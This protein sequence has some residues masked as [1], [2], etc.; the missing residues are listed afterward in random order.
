MSNDNNTLEEVTKSYLSTHDVYKLNECR[1]AILLS[2]NISKGKHFLSILD[3]IC[4]EDEDPVVKKDSVK[5]L[6]EVLSRTENVFEGLEVIEFLSK[7]TNLTICLHLCVNS[8]KALLERHFERAEDKDYKALERYFR[9]LAEK[10]I[11]QYPQQCRI[12][13]L[14]ISH[15]MVELVVK[16]KVAE[17]DIELLCDT[18]SEEKD[19]RNLLT[20]FELLSKLAKSVARKDEEFESIAKTYL[21]YFPIQFVP[22]KRDK[23]CIRPLELKKGLLECFKSNKRL[24]EYSMELL[25]DSLYSD[26]TV[27]ENQSV[28]KDTL[29]FLKNCK[30]VYRSN[31]D[32]FAKYFIQV[33]KMELLGTPVTESSLDKLKIRVEEPRSWERHSES[34]FARSEQTGDSRVNVVLGTDG[35]VTGV[36]NLMKVYGSPGNRESEGSRVTSSVQSSRELSE[37]EEN[38]ENVMG[39][40]MRGTGSMEEKA[41]EGDDLGELDVDQINKIGNAY[42]K[43]SSDLDEKVWVFGEIMRL[44]L[45]S[46][47]DVEEKEVVELLDGIRKTIHLNY[48]LA[49]MV[50]VLSENS[51]L[52]NKIIERI[53]LP[54]IKDVYSL[55]DNS[56]RNERQVGDDLN[57]DDDDLEI[58]DDLEDGDEL[59][60]GE[61]SQPVEKSSDEKSG[62]E[63]TGDKEWNKIDFNRKGEMCNIHTIIS[64]CIMPKILINF[65]NDNISEELLV[66]LLRIDRNNNGFFKYNKEG[67]SNYL[68]LLLLSSSIVKEKV[69]YEV[70]ERVIG[71]VFVKDTIVVSTSSGGGIDSSP[72]NTSRSIDSSTSNNTSADNTTS[73]RIVV[74]W[75][76]KDSYW[77]E[78]ALNLKILTAIYKSHKGICYTI[79]KVLNSM[80]PVNVRVKG[81]NYIL[82]RMGKMS[83]KS[84]LLI[85]SQM[86]ELLGITLN[87]W[88]RPKENYDMD[89]LVRN[90]IQ[91]VFSGLE[92]MVRTMNRKYIT[93]YSNMDHHKSNSIGSRYPESPRKDSS[94]DSYEASSS[95]I[96]RCSSDSSLVMSDSGPTSIPN[97]DGLISGEMSG[98]N[99]S[100]RMGS[101]SESIS[102]ILMADYKRV[103]GNGKESESKQH[104]GSNVTLIRANSDINSSNSISMEVLQ[105]QSHMDSFRE[106]VD[107]RDEKDR[108]GFIGYIF[109][110]LKEKVGTIDISD[111]EEK[112]EINY[113]NAMRIIYANM[114]IDVLES[115][116]KTLFMEMYERRRLVDF[117]ATTF[118][119]YKNALGVAEDSLYV[120]VF[121]AKKVPLILSIL[122]SSL[123][124]DMRKYIDHR[125]M[126]INIYFNRPELCE[127]KS[128]HTE[129]CLENIYYNYGSVE[130]SLVN[131]E[132]MVVYNEYL[133]NIDEVFECTYSNGS[134]LVKCV[135]NMYKYDFKE[136]TEQI[137]LLDNYKLTMREYDELF[138]L[139]LPISLNYKKGAYRLQMID[140]R[141][142]YRRMYETSKEESGVKGVE[143]G[144]KNFD[145]RTLRLLDILF[146]KMTKETHEVM[147]N[148]THRLAENYFSK[149]ELNV[150]FLL[151][152][153]HRGAV[154]IS[155]EYLRE[156]VESMSEMVRN[157]FKYQ[158]E[159]QRKHEKDGVSEYVNW[160]CDRY[161]MYIQAL[162]F[163]VVSEINNSA[164]E[165][166]M[167]PLKKLLTLKLEGIVEDLLKIS[168]LSKVPF[169]RILA[170]L[171][172]HVIMSS[173]QLRLSRECR[174]KVIKH[175]SKFLGDSSKKVR[176]IAVLCRQEWLS[177]QEE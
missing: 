122:G 29:Y 22:P 84:N 25:L 96:S 98:S 150:S 104:G 126:F 133:K 112:E 134:V 156:V 16:G 17:F 106:F 146:E 88:T 172:T 153:L 120:E 39:E 151:M 140:I 171:T 124:L 23:I 62:D 115:P 114:L 3:G 28:L 58:S 12:D 110:G 72:K 77:A 166:E 164:R 159:K 63:K 174:R 19:P 129:S 135:Q 2:V 97:T 132:T 75:E 119:Y 18:I 94:Y 64:K 118:N 4:E 157:I 50:E 24:A 43:G 36:A 138:F 48:S 116:C 70:I 143:G 45:D 109:R 35:V 167:E 78:V 51:K 44:F 87:K 127:N 41:V 53:V 21:V 117:F 145:E 105:S 103:D 81:S 46:L 139:F 20:M 136:I 83:T 155:E 165:K 32:K 61:D 100:S 89:R 142:R 168:K 27:D 14:K 130:L 9:T 34:M 162:L 170:I 74:K 95:E 99:I 55:F 173:K 40:R 149:L 37:V 65:K 10:K 49:Y 163:V 56:L 107:K 11:S 123:E 60:E 128:K 47:G 59:H 1:N 38:D 121:K 5:L 147:P 66:F 144:D 160:C 68:K 92:E 67:V 82:T 15:Y 79:V 175:S 57:D 131:L 177:K 113:N 111:S 54:L 152:L 8:T 93:V 91:V 141:E 33:V 26:F 85:S 154:K 73:A 125:T 102:N 7:C 42:Y 80:V 76:Q 148:Y 31:F 137:K 176:A 161:L 90:I 86:A 108:F 101:I 52:H 30:P 71:N 69:I 169:A 158:E 13:F 6:Y